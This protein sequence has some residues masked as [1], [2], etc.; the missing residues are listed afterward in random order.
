MSTA[1][2]TRLFW[3]LLTVLA[4]AACGAADKPEDVAQAFFKAAAAG[5]ADAVIKLI[6]LEEVPADKMMEAKGKVQMIVGEAAREAKANGGLKKIEVLETSLETDQDRAKV[7][8]GL[9]FG[10]GKEDTESMAL[11]RNAKKWQVVIGG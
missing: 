1:H 11:R 10:N 6:Y 8:V 4:L 2:L 7:K 5:N 3:L 9:T